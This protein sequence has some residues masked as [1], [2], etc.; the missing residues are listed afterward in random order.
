MINRFRK[1]SDRL[2]R[3]SAPSINDVVMLK[4][5]F[6]ITKIVSLDF[7]YGIKINRVCKVL[8]IKHIM[9]PIFI[10][11]KNARSSLIKF[12]KQDI[13]KLLTDADGSVFVHCAIGRDRTGLAVALYRCE[14]QG[15]SYEKAIKEAKSFGFGIGV[16]PDIVK[17]Y[18]K[19]IKKSCNH[20]DDVGFAY[21]IVSNEREDDY[22]SEG[23][24]ANSWMPSEDFRVRQYPYASG[25]NEWEEQYPSRLDY[26]IDEYVGSVHNMIQPG[27][28]NSSTQGINGAGPS[29][30]GSGYV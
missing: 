11:H 17:L 19:I 27:Q 15:W 10:D 14:K 8:G 18:E 21:D 9:S 6:N 23:R 25:Y 16:H 4:N 12:L 28:F 22:Y 3:G 24:G 26:N 30:V 29:M 20:K 2:Y 5:K 1:V 7:N 13:G